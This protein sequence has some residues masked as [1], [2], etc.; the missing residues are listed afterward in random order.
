MR[1]VLSWL[2]EFVDVSASAEEIA[3]TIG[4]RGFEVASIEPRDGGDA[5]IDF[6]I[7]ANRP[8]CLSVI[9]LAREV[10]TVFDLPVRA[11]SA[12]PA[13]KARLAST[14]VGGSDRLRVTIEDADLC[15]RYAAAVADVTIGPSPAWLASRLQAA[16]VRP[17]NTIVDITNYVTI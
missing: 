16:G 2:K 12:D 17:I 6:E 15:P 10:A 14:P 3:E 8:D 13:A 11:H 5:V 1:L 4:L 7:T 9:G